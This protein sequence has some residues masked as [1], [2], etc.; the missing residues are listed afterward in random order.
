M[1]KCSKEELQKIFEVEQAR[2][3]AIREA[4]PWS[5][6][7]AYVGWLVNSYEYAH[8]STR[9][10]AMTGG[11]FPLDKTSFSNRFISHAA[12]EK[13]HERLLENDLKNFGLSLDSVK[14]NVT[15]KAFHHS[16]YYWIYEGNPIGMFGWVLA[17]EGFA[18]RNVP[19]MYEICRETFGPKCSSFLKV[20]AEEDE[21]HLAKAFE[22]IKGFSPEEN[23]LVAETLQFYAQLYG[24][25][26]ET[27]KEL[28]LKGSNKKAA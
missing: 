15:G 17:L 18:V 25:V 11:R 20:H 24:N 8:K 27:T 4:F 14:P 9:I 12:E 10:L 26:L 21:D 6:R 7:E 16:L 5:N 1:K 19:A 22:S 28:A 13:G 23:A 2:L 3:K